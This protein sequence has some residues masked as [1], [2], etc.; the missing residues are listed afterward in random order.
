[1]SYDNFTSPRADRASAHV[2]IFGIASI[3]V[4][5]FFGGPVAAGLLVA[6][7]ATVQRG[8]Q[9]LKAI[10]FFAIASTAWFWLLYRVPRDVLS[11]LVVHIPQVLI[12]WIACALLLRGTLAAHAAAGGAFRSVR[13]AMG[14]GL[15]VGVVVRVVLRIL[16]PSLQ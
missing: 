6:H 11:E 2:S 9:N 16:L 1:M 12:W 5:G 10:A 4:A 8:S 14:F 7:N 3:I 13:S 15:L